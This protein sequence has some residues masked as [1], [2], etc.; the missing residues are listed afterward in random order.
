MNYFFNL[1]IAPSTLVV[2]Q[3]DIRL[4][5]RTRYKLTKQIS[6]SCVASS[7]GRVHA[8]DCPVLGHSVARKVRDGDGLQVYLDILPSEFWRVTFENGFG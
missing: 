8:I 1:Y 5:I 3:G 6:F 4:L 7:A 2:V